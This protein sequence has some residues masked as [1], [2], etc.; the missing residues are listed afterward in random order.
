MKIT[1]ECVEE[2]HQ[3]FRGVSLDRAE[4]RGPRGGIHH[5]WRASCLRDAQVAPWHHTRASAAAAGWTDRVY[6]I[7]VGS[8]WVFGTL[9]APTDDDAT[10]RANALNLDDPWHIVWGGRHVDVR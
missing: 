3:V 10:R 8:G 1:I 9:A 6:N 2:C 5:G 4:W 7:V